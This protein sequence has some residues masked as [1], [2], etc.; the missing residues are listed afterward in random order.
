MG[1]GMKCFRGPHLGSLYSAPRPPNW[2]LGGT[3]KGRTEGVGGGKDR[4]SGK[5]GQAADG[6]K[7][8][9]VGIDPQQKFGKSSTV[10]F[11]YIDLVI[12]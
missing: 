3:H 5:V 9:K 7:G 1:M 2:I 11:P 6:E 8:R 12:I 4:K 10:R